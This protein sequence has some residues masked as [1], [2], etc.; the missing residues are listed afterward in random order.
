MDIAVCKG[1]IPVD[2]RIALQAMFTNP[3]FAAIIFPMVV[4][5]FSPSNAGLE[6]TPN[7]NEVNDNL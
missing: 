6:L 4:L 5:Q 3:I 1:S 7:G 2:A